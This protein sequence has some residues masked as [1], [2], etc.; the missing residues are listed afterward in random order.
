MTAKKKILQCMLVFY[1]VYSEP[2]RNISGSVVKQKDG[3]ETVKVKKARQ[4]Q[5]ELRVIESS[6]DCWA[7]A[8]EHHGERMR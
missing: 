4:R 8:A 1:S 3:G 5:I 2:D 7:S 6:E